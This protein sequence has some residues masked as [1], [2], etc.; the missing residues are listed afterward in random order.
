MFA[1]KDFA[2]SRKA[3]AVET[4]SICTAFLYSKPGGFNEP[5]AKPFGATS[6][7]PRPAA[8]PHRTSDSLK[9][10]LARLHHKSDVG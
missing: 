6:T 8:G 5:S 3:S 1:R 10:R 4:V 2:L 9:A 7:N